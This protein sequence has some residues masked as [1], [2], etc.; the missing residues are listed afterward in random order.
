M[1]KN[2][3]RANAHNE[4]I[5]HITAQYVEQVQAGW[6]PSLG[7]YLV[8]YPAYIDALVDF[9]AYYH[10][11]EEHSMQKID[12]IEALS[13]VSQRAL[14]RAWD[15]ISHYEDNRPY[16][17][18]T[19]LMARD[20]LCISLTSLARELDLS[21]DIVMQLEQREIDP[22]SIPLELSMRLSQV[23]QQPLYLIQA[24]LVNSQQQFSH[25]NR[26]TRLRV[27]EQ[28][29]IYGVPV[30]EGMLS[31]RQALIDSEQVSDRQRDSWCRIIERENCR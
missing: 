19:L 11:F 27:A 7:D 13:E 5:V 14:E 3:L 9:V 17:L 26:E 31:F 15:Y 30:R 24:Y 12:G 1:K 8:R 23:I 28:Q 10:A 21:V 18:P 6:K 25:K 22:A 2:T 4:A 16:Q 20:N 29:E